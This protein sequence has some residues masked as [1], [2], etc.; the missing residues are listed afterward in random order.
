MTRIASGEHPEHAVNYWLAVLEKSIPCPKI[1][2]LIF[3]QDL[4]PEA[5]VAQARTYKPMQL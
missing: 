5:V 4:S 3:W 1:R 2:D